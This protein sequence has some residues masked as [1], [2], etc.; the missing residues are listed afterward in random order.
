[1]TVQCCMCKRVRID[2]AWQCP[3]G[4]EPAPSSTY[5]PTCFDRYSRQL[6]TEREAF[7]QDRQALVRRVV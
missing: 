6:A 1:M 2:D 7:R 5:C 3:A 4:V